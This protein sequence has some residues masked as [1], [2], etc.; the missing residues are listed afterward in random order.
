MLRDAGKLGIV[1]VLVG[2]VG[3]AAHRLKEANKAKVN[4]KSFRIIQ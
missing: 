2:N 4:V 1:S 3:N